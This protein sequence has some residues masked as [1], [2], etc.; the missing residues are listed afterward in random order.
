MPDTSDGAAAPDAIAST[1]GGAGTVAAWSRPEL[2][3][4]AP[5]GIA[6]TTPAH[7][8]MSAGQN[9]SL[10]AGQDINLQSQRHTA[11]AVKAGIS[12]FTYGKA[13]N[14]SKPNTETGLQMHAASG[15]VSVQAQASTLALTADK[16]IAVSSVTDAIT[17]GS[18]THV[19]FAAGG[20]SLRI[21]S[22]GIT[23]TTS[24]AANFKAALKELTGAGSAQSSLSLPVAQPL[25]GCAMKLGAATQSG[26]AGVAR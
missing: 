8:V 24:G 25:K 12:L 22:G 15:N 2:L 3:V 5:G 6:A 14:A 7:S 18:P 19:L 1:Q 21:T 20:S 11:I 10:A 4:S 16:S 17:M 13:Q 26:A 23:L 9:A